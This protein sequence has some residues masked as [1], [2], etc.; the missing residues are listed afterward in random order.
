MAREQPLL[1]DFLSLR[2]SFGGRVVTR[3]ASQRAG[4][5]LAWSAMKVGLTPS[6][7][8]L[9]ALLAAIAGSVLL[10]VS[11]SGAAWWVPAMVVLQLSYALDCADGQ[12][13]RGTKRTSAF[14]GWLDVSCDHLRQVALAMASADLLLRSGLGQGPTLFAVALFLGGS[15]VVLHTST[16]LRSPGSTSEELAPDRLHVLRL[17]LTTV[18]DTPVMIVFLV[19]LRDHP[20]LLAGYLALLGAY[21]LLMAAY[22]GLRRLGPAQSSAP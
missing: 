21:Y 7:V 8:T 15:T 13:A 10:D 17:V 18:T 22:L 4:A 19:V 2:Y 14:G 9:L 12:L 11:P 20:G 5:A 3:T 1:G 6:A 16:H